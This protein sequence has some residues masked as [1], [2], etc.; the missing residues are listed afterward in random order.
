MCVCVC[1]CVRFPSQLCAR[2]LLVVVLVEEREGVGPSEA[3]PEQSDLDAPDERLDL[4][5]LEDALL[6]EQGS[7]RSALPRPQTATAAG[8]DVFKQGKAVLPRVSLE[9]PQEERQGGRVQV[10]L[11]VKEAVEGVAESRLEARPAWKRWG[12]VQHPRRFER[13]TGEAEA[14]R[15]PAPGRRRPHLRREGREEGRAEGQAV[16]AAVLPPGAAALATGLRAF[17]LVVLRPGSA[18]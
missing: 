5:H 1:V 18:R 10:P 17:A 16:F 6:G 2:E 9:L 3:V 14:Q 4:H 13:R 11:R 12:R 15:H 8:A 7:E